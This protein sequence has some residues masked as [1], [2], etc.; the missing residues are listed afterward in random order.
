MSYTIGQLAKTYQVSR[1]TLIYYDKLGLLTPSGRRQN[2]YRHYTQKDRNRLEKIIGYRETGMSLDAIKTLLN[3][4]TPHRRTQALQDQL[5]QLNKEILRLKK[6]QQITLELLEST[7]FNTPLANMNKAQ[8]TTLLAATGMTDEDMWHWHKE[9]EMR[10]P[11]AHQTFLESLN[12]DPD[13]I[14]QIRKRSQSL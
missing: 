10:M 14:Q 8:W 11:D 12:I 3:N 1:S 7:G 5:E 13:E 6:Q 2:N 4:Q 9:F